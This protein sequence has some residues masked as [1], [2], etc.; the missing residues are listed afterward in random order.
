[1]SRRKAQINKIRGEKG[2][3]KTIINENLS[4]IWEYIKNWYSNKLKNQ[5][6]MDKFL[7][8]YDQPKLN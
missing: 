6:E 2:T 7:D 4:I 8:A 3:I 5:E 1:M